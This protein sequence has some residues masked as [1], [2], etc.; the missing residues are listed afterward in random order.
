LGVAGAIDFIRAQVIGGRLGEK[1]DA[2]TKAKVLRVLGKVMH[3]VEAHTFRCGYN[4]GIE[5]LSEGKLDRAK[6]KTG[7]RLQVQ[8]KEIS[9]SGPSWT[10]KVFSFHNELNLMDMLSDVTDL[11][12][13]QKQAYKDGI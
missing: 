2:D 13:I 12:E 7:L 6:A 3:Y 10:G 9:T 4:L 5:L 1:L 8:G 11:A